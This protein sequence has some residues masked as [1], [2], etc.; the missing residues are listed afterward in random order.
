PLTPP[1]DTPMITATPLPKATA[2]AHRARALA[3]IL[4][5]Q[6]ALRTAPDATRSIANRLE[7]AALSFETD[8]APVLDGITDTNTVPGDAALAII[9]AEILAHDNPGTTLPTDFGRYITAPIHG[10]EPS[11]P[12]EL[13]PASPQLARQ[14]TRLR[15]VLADIHAQLS[16][17]T[18]PDML[19]DHLASVLRWHRQWARLSDAV[20]IDNARP[21]NLPSSVPTLPEAPGT[22]PDEGPDL[23]GLTAYTISV[24]RLAKS[25]GLHPQWGAPRGNARRLI[26]NASG[27]HGAFGSIQVGRTSGKILRAEIIPGNGRKPL[28]S[29]GTNAV[30][31][32]LKALPASACPSGCSAPS[33]VACNS[34]N[35][36]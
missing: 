5:E 22:S 33:T 17:T 25:K 10:R 9:D 30:R 1:G 16:A 2:A 35:R 8:P 7:A 31:A 14:E 20:R 29:Q 32:A 3:H 24:I 4:R 6:S 13:H 12:A 15:Q 26:L 36:P 28:L 19:R 21:C 18:H 34:T 11:Q 23:T 27:P